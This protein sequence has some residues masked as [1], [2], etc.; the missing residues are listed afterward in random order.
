MAHSNPTSRNRDRLYDLSKAQTPYRAQLRALLT[1]P[2]AELNRA[3]HAMHLDLQCLLA[4]K[5]HSQA[6]NPVPTYMA[7]VLA[8][9]KLNP[10][11]SSFRNWRTLQ[12]WYRSYLT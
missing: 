1:L 4:S 10:P 9:H 5:V 6:T 2:D 3:A 12:N 11:P 7:D 8:K